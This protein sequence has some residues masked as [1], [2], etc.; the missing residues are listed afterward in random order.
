MRPVRC[1]FRRVRQ[2]L[3]FLLFSALLLCVG[4]YVGLYAPPECHRD[5][6]GYREVV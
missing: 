6:I 3:M 1:S 4:C 5:I 2:G